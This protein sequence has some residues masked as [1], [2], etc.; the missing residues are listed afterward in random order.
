VFCCVGDDD[1]VRAMVR[2]PD[3]ALAAM[4]AGAVLVDHTT[5]SAELAR[6]LAAIARETGVGFVD[7]PV[8][9]G[10]AGA[11]QG[12][13]TVMAGGRGDRFHA[14]GTPDPQLRACRAAARG[15]RVPASSAR[16]ST[17]S[18]SPA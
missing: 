12:V 6:E 3:G 8:S 2:G 15:P 9:G 1:S 7:A 5:A 16:W 13:L 10:E 11:R 4:R 17:R 18:A 14:G